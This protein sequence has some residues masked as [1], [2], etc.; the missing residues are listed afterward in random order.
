MLHQGVDP[1]LGCVPVQGDRHLS[2]GKR[3]GPDLHAAD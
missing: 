1:R 2:A 3:I